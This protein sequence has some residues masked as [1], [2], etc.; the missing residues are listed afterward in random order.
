MT[1]S[2]HA[3]ARRTWIPTVLLFAVS[4]SLPAAYFGVSFGHIPEAPLDGPPATGWMLFYLWYTCLPWSM[5]I[6]PWYANPIW[7]CGVIALMLKEP[8]AALVFGI[9]ATLLALLTLRIGLGLKGG[10]WGEWPDAGN[11]HIGYYVWLGSM[12]ALMGAA[13]YEIRRAPSTP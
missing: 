5:V 6:V 7:L 1:P 4:L 2:T 11:F 13:A 10:F 3:A 8:W 12:L 9:I